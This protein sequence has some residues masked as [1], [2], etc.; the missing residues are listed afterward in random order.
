MISPVNGKI[1]SR[2]GDIKD[3]IANDGINIKAALGTPVKAA[4]S[5]DVIYA[6]NDKLPEFGNTVVIQHP[7]SLITS[8]AHLDKIKAKSGTAVNA[9]NVIGTVGKTGDV[10]ESQLHFEVLKDKNPVNPEKYQKN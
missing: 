5:G 8:Y 10:T 1:I 9:G 2:F 7:N 6:G 3:G 4:A